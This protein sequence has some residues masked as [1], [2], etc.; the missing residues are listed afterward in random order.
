MPTIKPRIQVMPTEEL[1]N[2]FQDQAKEMGIS[3]SS[4]IV[5]AMKQYKQQHDALA[6]MK[7]LPA[8][9]EE[10]K[11]LQDKQLELENK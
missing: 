4:L 1:K 7:G 10:L 3:M 9:M 8:I 5:V 11:K 2:W 6:T